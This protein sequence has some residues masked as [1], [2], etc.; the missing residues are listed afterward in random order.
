MINS[1]CKPLASD[2]PTVHSANGGNNTV[3]GFTYA[4]RYLLWLLVKFGLFYLILHLC[5]PC[6][7]LMLLSQAPFG[8]NKL[9]CATCSYTTPHPS[10]YVWRQAQN[11]TKT[12]RRVTAYSGGPLRGV[13][14]GGDEGPPPSSRGR[15]A[16]GN[17]IP[18][19]LSSHICHLYQHPDRLQNHCHFGVDIWDY[20][21][22]H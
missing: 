1:P 20:A 22:N 8:W 13:A 19:S 2:I 6:H 7:P 11:L 3:I 16:N 15:P 4:R 9:A 18:P 5:I 14:S 12:D 10:S 17:H 21:N